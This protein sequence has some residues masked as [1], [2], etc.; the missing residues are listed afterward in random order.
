MTEP[1]YQAMLSNLRV[2]LQGKSGNDQPVKMDDTKL[3][4][5]VDTQNREQDEEYDKRNGLYTHLLEVYISNYR[6]KEKAKGIYKGIF[7]TVTIILFVGIVGIGLAG[8]FRLSVAGDGSLANVGIAI[9]NI[10]G[11]VSTLVILPKIIAEHLFPADEESNMLEM[12]KGMQD[13]DSKIRNILY[14]GKEHRTT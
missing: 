12:V 3:N 6:R 13:N 7:F 1:Q 10:A 4:M 14:E 9:T 8:T 5:T 11:I 2:T